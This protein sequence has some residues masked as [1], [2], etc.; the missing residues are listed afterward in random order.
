VYS[1]R[2]APFSAWENFPAISTDL[3]SA[4]LLGEPNAKLDELHA[5]SFGSL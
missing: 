4:R 5:H 2:P 1:T 3:L